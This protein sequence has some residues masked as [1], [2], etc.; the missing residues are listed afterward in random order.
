MNQGIRLRTL[1]FV[2]ILASSTAAVAACWMWFSSVRAWQNHLTD[3]FVAGVSLY[4]A[5]RT[6]TEG[7]PGITVSDLASSDMALADKGDFSHLSNIPIPAFVTNVSIIGPSR[8]PLTGEVLFIG[9]VSD[10]MQ[11]AV[12][13]LVSNE[14]QPAAQKFGN[15]T[16]L[17]A[18]YCSD[19]ILFTR[20]GDG[21]WQR[22]DGRQVWGCNAAPRDLRLLAALLSLA[23]LAV[24]ATLVLDTSSYF[25]RFAR[26]LRNRRQLGGPDSY[27]VQG[28]EELRDIVVAVNS[29]LENEREQLVKR[30]NVLSGVSH[31]LGAPA[32]LASDFELL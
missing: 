9:I 23:V 13:E 15:V 30:A 18:T 3:S 26:A 22:V 12:S 11:Y 1:G 10:K 27:A 2:L 21:N 24:L 6:G 17:L 7:P 25:D 4:E 29:Y 8:D 28:P 20:I 14:G 32:T 19:P 5:I 16:R 31:D